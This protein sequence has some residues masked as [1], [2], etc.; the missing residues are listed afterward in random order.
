V[1]HEVYEF[2]KKMEA[3]GRLTGYR[4][5]IRPLSRKHVA[6][7]L[8]RVEG[9][10]R[11]LSDVDLRRL[12]FFKE[13]FGDELGMVDSSWTEAP[14]RWHP[15]TFVLDEGLLNVDLNAAFLTERSQADWRQRVS[16]GLRMYGYV[17]GN[18]GFSFHFADNREIGTPL[19]PVRAVSPED[20]L[21][22][23]KRSAHSFEYDFTDV[24]LSYQTG[25]MTFSL[26]KIPMWWST[27]RRGSLMLSPKAPAAPQ[28]RFRAELAEWLDFTYIHAELNSQVLDSLR[29]YHT[30]TSSIHDYVRPVYRQKYMA[31]HVLEASVTD[32]LEVSFGESI[33]YSDRTPQI[34][35]LIPVM[36]FKSGEH[37]NQDTDNSQFFLSADAHPGWGS[38][39]YASVF[40]DE[41]ATSEIFNPDK[42]R[43][44]LGFTVGMQS[45]DLLLANTELMIEYSRLNPWVYS[46]RFQ[47]ATF[48]NAGYDM[49]HWIGQNADLLT[50]EAVY[51]PW[52]NVRAS[53]WYEALRKGG[54]TDVSFQYTTPSQPFLYGPVRRETSFGARVVYEPVRDLFLEASARSW[55]VA[56]EGVPTA[57]HADKPEFSLSFRYGLR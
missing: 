21:I 31:A 56:D 33:V 26:E 45:F 53:A 32:W 6:E 52:R 1:R 42:V 12:T 19:D 18:V 36:F 46:H 3:Q 22:I 25:G 11:F 47:A 14:R 44:Q 17:F 16:N 13:E 40:I 20:G 28:L 24:E 43:N 4:D 35:Y 41:I 2:L 29:S 49:G 23:S 55:R 37:Y 34:M 15:L 9:S 38:N 10:A 50:V 48:Q 39:L 7:M 30:Y 51:R 57:S 54:R 8:L 27:G 5:I